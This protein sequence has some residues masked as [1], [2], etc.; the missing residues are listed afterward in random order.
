[1]AAVIV[2]ATG[3]YLAMGRWSE[4]WVQVSV[5]AFLASGVLANVAVKVGCARILAHAEAG[6][7]ERIDGALEA[8]R[9]SARLGVGADLL[10]AM[11]LAAVFLMTVQPAGIGAVVTPAVA[12]VAVLLIRWFLH[13]SR[14]SPASALPD[15]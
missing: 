14:V 6:D 12:V 8:L 10:A 7:E 13:R 1:M 3:I 4:T 9:T 15:V 11:D 2:L 5:I